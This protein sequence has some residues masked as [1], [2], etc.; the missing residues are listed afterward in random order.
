MPLAAYR[1]GLA[2]LLEPQPV[3][4]KLRLPV[5]SASRSGFTDLVLSRQLISHLPEAEFRQLPALHWIPT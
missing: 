2:A 4:A 1:Q 3:F 5:L